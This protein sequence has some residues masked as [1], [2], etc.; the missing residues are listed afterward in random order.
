[1]TNTAAMMIM[2]AATRALKGSAPGCRTCSSTGRSG[3]GS[4][5]EVSASGVL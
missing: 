1:V 3:S 5:G 4:A 2:R